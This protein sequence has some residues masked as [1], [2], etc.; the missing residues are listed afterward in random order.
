MVV[1]LLVGGLPRVWEDAWFDALLAFEVVIGLFCEIR[2]LSLGCLTLLPF[3]LPL[4]GHRLHILD[5][6]FLTFRS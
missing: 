1:K 5:D 4:Y 2:W 6:H 3:N